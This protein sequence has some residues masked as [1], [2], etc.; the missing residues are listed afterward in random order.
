M[1]RPVVVVSGGASSEHDVSRASGRDVSEALA[2]NPRYLV[3]DAFVDRL[4]GWHVGGEDAPGGDV[5]DVLDDMPAD[6]IVFPALHGGWGEGGGLQRELELRGIRFVGSGADASRTA[7]SKRTTLRLCAEAGVR[8]IPTRSIERARYLADPDLVAGTVRR[9][10]DDVVVKPDTGG[11][12]IGVHVVKAGASLRTALADAFADDAVALVQPLVTGDEV[13]V[14]V[15][16]DADGGTHATG[17]SLLHLPDDARHEG[18]SYAHKYEGAGAVLEIPAALPTDTLEGL[19]AAA[20]RCF[21]AIG[22]RG[23]ARVD[24]FV[25]EGGG[26][27]LNE[28]NTIPGLRHHSHFPRLV[29]AAGTPYPRLLELL[30]DAAT[31]RATA[32]RC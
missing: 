4:G 24:F 17:A 9:A 30:V 22:G 1:R 18:F 16:Q 3:V 32:T 23:M 31:T 27:L 11:S 7:L 10:V 14:G 25:E 15:W 28:I 2:R 29:A 21:R 20:L 5:A 26:I 12:S 19:Q 8:V 13:S 6:A